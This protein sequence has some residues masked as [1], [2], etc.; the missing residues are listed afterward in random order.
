MENIGIGFAKTKPILAPGMPTLEVRQPDD[1]RENLILK[2]AGAALRK[3]N[4]CHR[5]SSDR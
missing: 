1:F 5:S 3:P 4:R 2:N